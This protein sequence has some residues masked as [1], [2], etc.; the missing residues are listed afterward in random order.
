MKAEDFN[1]EFDVYVVDK[2]M[3]WTYVHT[4]EDYFNPYFFKKTA[5]NNIILY[6]MLFSVYV[7]ISIIYKF[8]IDF[9]SN[10]TLIFIISIF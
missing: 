9:K 4:H 3:S 2:N 1:N 7:D 6:L 8:F 10:L 5:L